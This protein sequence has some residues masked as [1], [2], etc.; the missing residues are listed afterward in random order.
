MQNYNF[1][2]AAVRE[3]MELKVLWDMDM[4]L[5]NHTIEHNRPGMMVNDTF[6]RTAQIIDFAVP[7]DDNA[8]K[9]HAEKSCKVWTTCKRN[10]ENIESLTDCN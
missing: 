2:P 6:N 5:T 4:T 8:V 1:T 9:T 7:L 3:N 10:Y